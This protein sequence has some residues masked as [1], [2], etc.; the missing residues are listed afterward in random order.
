MVFSIGYLVLGIG[1]WVL[2]IGYTNLLKK[3][4]IDFIIIIW[5]QLLKIDFQTKLRLMIF[6]TIRRFFSDGFL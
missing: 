2:G 6:I 4:K 5:N 3:I 1:Y